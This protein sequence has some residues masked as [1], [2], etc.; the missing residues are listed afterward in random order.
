MAFNLSNNGSTLSFARASGNVAIGSSGYITGQS[1]GVYINGTGTTAIATTGVLNYRGTP[2]LLS[3]LG[4]LTKKKGEIFKEANL[5]DVGLPSE[6]TRIHRKSV[7]V[8]DL[9]RPSVYILYFHDEVVYV[10]QSTNPYQ[11]MSQHMRDK[12]F[13]HIRVMTCKRTRMS[14]WEKRLIQFYRPRYN[15]THNKKRSHLRAV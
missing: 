10:G 12:R 7:R 9:A 1:T 5:E 3:E 14:H 13:T 8:T 11:R 6:S 2:Y 4:R 15:V